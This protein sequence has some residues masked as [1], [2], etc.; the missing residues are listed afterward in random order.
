MERPSQGVAH[1]AKRVQSALSKI[2]DMQTHKKVARSFSH[3]R[4]GRIGQPQKAFAIGTI[5]GEGHS[6]GNQLASASKAL[7][8]VANA[9][10]FWT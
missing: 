9:R 10:E 1:S 8:R 6:R 4:P 3:A 5:V 7:R 2:N